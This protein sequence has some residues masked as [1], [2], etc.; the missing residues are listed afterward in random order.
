V[1]AACN[2]NDDQCNFDLGLFCDPTAAK[3][4]E[5][6]YA[7]AGQPCDQLTQCLASADCIATA[8]MAATGTCTAAAKEGEACS[9]NKSCLPPSGCARDMVCH[10]PLPLMCM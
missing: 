10:L 8:P 9:Q 6:K 7:A 1:G 2:P 5:V 4:V 3:C